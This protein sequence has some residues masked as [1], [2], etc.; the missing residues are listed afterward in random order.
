MTEPMRRFFL[1]ALLPL[2]AHAGPV[3]DAAADYARHHLRQTPAHEAVGGC[4][5]VMS[6]TTMASHAQNEWVLRDYLNLQEDTE[7]ARRLNAV[8]RAAWAHRNGQDVLTLERAVM[9]G[10][11]A[12][13]AE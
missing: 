4:V 8:I 6:H 10:C 9:R 5:S 11:I 13:L 1:F 12:G 2:T 7:A 3:E